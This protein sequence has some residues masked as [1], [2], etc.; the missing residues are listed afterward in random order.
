MA[1]HIHLKVQM[2]LFNYLAMM[3][4]MVGVKAEST[5]NSL[6]NCA[7]CQTVQA[8][9]E[10]TCDVNCQIIQGQNGKCGT[11]LL[12]MNIPVLIYYYSYYIIKQKL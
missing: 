12:F 9:M 5:G 8:K 3:M 10:W 11:W 1:K 2:N 7:A 6:V 4:V